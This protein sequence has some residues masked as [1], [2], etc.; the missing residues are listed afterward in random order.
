MD[1]IKFLVNDPKRKQEAYQAMS[2]MYKHCDSEE[3]KEEFYRHFKSINADSSSDASF[4]DA[5]C[6]P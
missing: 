6:N 1:S 5:P 3:K 2:L 4:S